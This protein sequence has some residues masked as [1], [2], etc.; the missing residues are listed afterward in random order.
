MAIVNIGNVSAMEIDRWVAEG[1]PARN[2]GSFRAGCRCNPVKEQAFDLATQRQWLEQCPGCRAQLE[3]TRGLPYAPT[4]GAFV[5]AGTTGVGPTAVITPPPPMAAPDPG[6]GPMGPT[7]NGLRP[8]QPGAVSADPRGALIGAPQIQPTQPEAAMPRRRV[9]AVPVMAT[10]RSEFDLLGGI[11]GAI[12][13]FV[14][15]GPVGAITGGLGGLLDEPGERVTSPGT[16][17]RGRGLGL[18]AGCPFGFEMNPATGQCEQKGFR[19]AIERFLPGGETGTLQ[20]VYGDAVNGRYGVGLIPSQRPCAARLRCPPGMVL[21]KD[22][23]CYDKPLADSKRKWPVGR[24]PLL[25]GG[26]LNTLTKAD[27]LK[28]KV[29]TAWERADKPGPND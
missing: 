1:K 9:G 24:K 16:G 25:T 22:N 6:P 20:D 12:G 3:A 4:V 28:K 21:G 14:T 19:G 5:P 17:G 2:T 27:R 10:G 26:D 18:A 13:G 11:T 7:G 23:V 29:R 8:D 15:G